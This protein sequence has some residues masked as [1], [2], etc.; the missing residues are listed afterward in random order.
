MSPNRTP[1]LT[2]D[3]AAHGLA[4]QPVVQADLDAADARTGGDPARAPRSL[5]ASELG[6]DDEA[7]ASSD[8]WDDPERL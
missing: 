1:D 3:P 8:D 6:P 4:D 2:S 5:R 7:I